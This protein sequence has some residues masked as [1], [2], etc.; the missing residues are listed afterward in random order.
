MI[1][2]SGEVGGALLDVRG[3]SLLGILTLEED[4]L[5]LSLDGQTLGEGDLRA[6]LDGALDASDRLGGLVRG[7]EAA[8][9]TP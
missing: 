1:L 7:A 5:Q 8:W 4:L 2:P 3:D 6:R 9:Q